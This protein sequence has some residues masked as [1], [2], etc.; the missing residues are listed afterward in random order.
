VSLVDGTDSWRSTGPIGRPIIDAGPLG[1]LPSLTRRALRLEERIG[2]DGPK[3]GLAMLLSGLA[4]VLAEEIA[5]DRFEVIW[6]A[7]GLGRPGAI[8]E[9]T[10]PRLSTRVGL[11]LDPALAHAIVDRLLGF[12]RLPA[13]ARL[14]ITPVEWGILSFAIARA[15]D[16]LDREDGPLGPW[17]LMIGR[18]GPDPFNPSGLGP[19]VTWRWRVRLGPMTGSAR[20]WVP[21]SLLALW[22]SDEP[23]TGVRPPI[24]IGRL[25]DLSSA[26][27]AEAGHVEMPRGLGRL[28]AGSVLPIDGSPLTGTPQS[29]EGIVEL[30]L[31]DRS[32]R[33]RFLA[34]PDRNSAGARLILESPMSREPRPRETHAMAVPAEPTANPST[35]AGAVAPADVPVTLTVELGRINLSLGRIADLKPGD[36]LE[37]G[38][39]AREPVELTSGGRLI[40]RGELVQIDNELGV[41]V[42]HVFL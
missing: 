18:V 13:E 22:L 1:L 14:Q 39:H 37:L 9:L 20:L 7:S 25:G 38:R 15:L 28:R 16:R 42:T 12:E 5:A 11:G 32:G 33:T 3:A 4:G 21:E 2:P 34:H 23:S 10:W 6:R 29:P 27:R 40:A 30:A 24:P 26:W 36:V 41:R 35:G 31:T 8:A 19:M 17:D